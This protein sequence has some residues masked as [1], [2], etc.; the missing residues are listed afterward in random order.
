MARL[1]DVIFVDKCK[2]IVRDYVN[3]H[4]DKLDAYKKFE[5]RCIRM[6]ETR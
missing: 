6:E 3:D 2:E 4:L 5:N 1:T